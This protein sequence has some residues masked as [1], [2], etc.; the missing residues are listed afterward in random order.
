VPTA[1]KISPIFRGPAFT[2]AK[3]HRQQVTA[4]GKKVGASGRT[5]YDGALDDLL[6]GFDTGG[7][8]IQ[9]R[10]EFG[11]L[12]FNIFDGIFNGLQSNRRHLDHLDAILDVREAGGRGEDDFLLLGF[13]QI[14]RTRPVVRKCQLKQKFVCK[15]RKRK[16]Q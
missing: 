7:E 1:K 6:Q 16:K 14:L 13:C 11:D 3:R 4:K 8:G 5:W 15:V 2:T 12:A 9:F 10:A